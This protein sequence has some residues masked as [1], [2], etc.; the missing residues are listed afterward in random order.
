MPTERFKNPPTPTLGLRMQNRVY[1]PQQSNPIIVF[2][3]SAPPRESTSDASINLDQQATRDQTLAG[4]RPLMLVAGG[5]GGH[6]FPAIAVAEQAHKDNI[7]VVLVTDA[8]GARFIQKEHDLFCEPLIVLP[9][10]WS[11]PWFVWK[12]LRRIKPYGIL[13][14]G[15]RITVWPLILGRLLGAHTAIHQS[16]LVLGSANKL[17]SHLVH[18]C[19]C[20]APLAHNSGFQAVG[21]PVRQAFYILEPQSTGSSA[22]QTMSVPT[23]SL[24]TSHAVPPPND[25]YASRLWDHY[26]MSPVLQILVLGGSQGAAFWSHMLP[27]ALG[28]LSAD[29]QKRLVI[30]HQVRPEDQEATTLAYQHIHAKVTCQPFFPNM[31]QELINSH[32]VLTRAGAGTLAEL[33]AVGR[34]GFFV[35]YPYAQGHQKYNA[36]FATQ[37]QAGW[38]ELQHNISPLVIADFLHFCLSNPD[39]LVYTSKNMKNL[40]PDNAS[41]TL[42]HFVQPQS[43]VGP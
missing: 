26:H 5:T 11:H 1:W 30:R 15:G 35:P 6:M 10:T 25:A 31:A 27:Q 21:T 20:A 41:Y 23:N 32:V 7:P 39:K 12:I 37:H 17:L 28:M 24:P 42:A 2:M 33:S 13:G 43:F 29:E 3:I 4:K 14:M 34:P 22:P 36:E 19:F 38:M 40:L 18:Q 16:D 9:E 8:R